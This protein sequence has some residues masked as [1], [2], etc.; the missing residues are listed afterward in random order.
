MFQGD[1]HANITIKEFHDILIIEDTKFIDNSLKSTLEK[2]KYTCQQSFDYSNASFLL[3]NNKFNFIILDLHLPDAYGEE[4]VGKIK[5]LAQDAK[6]IILTTEKDFQTRDSLFKFGI[7]DYI[8]KDKNF[9]KS[10][11]SIDKI[12]KS[13]KNNYLTSILIINDSKLI[14][15]HVQNI[16]SVKNYNIISAF[17][18]KDALE[19]LDKQKIS[20]I[21]LDMELPDMHGLS[22]LQKIKN[23]KKLDDVSVVILSG[24]NNP[25]LL[26][27]SI[28]Q[29]ALDYIK[30]PFN[31]EEFTLKIDIAIS[32][33]KKHIELL[34]NQQILQEYKDA[35]DKSSIVSKTNAQGLIT[36]VNNN[37]CNISG[38]TRDELMGRSHNIVRHGDMPSSI[39]E[40]M[41]ITIKNKKTWAGIIKNRNKDNGSY[42]V[43]TV[44]NPV[45]DYNGNIIEYISIRT[46]VTELENIKQELENNLN[47]SNKN[48][49]EAYKTAQ[50]Y[51]T[52]IDK[53]N[54]LSRA[55]IDGKITYVNQEFCKISA[56]TK[57]EL[58]GQS[59]NIL[60][61][62]DNPKSLYQ[63][64]WQTIS[65]GKI[66]NHKQL[67]NKAKD[68][69]T[70]YLNTTII[71]ILDD[72]KLIEYLAVRHDVTDIVDV[73]I[74][75]ENAQIEIIHKLGEV[76]E[77]RS[78]EIGFHIKRVAE[79]SK[80]LALLAGLGNKNANLL[81]L[82]SPMHDI[83]KIGI[84]DSIL[85]KPGKLDSDEWTIMKTHSEIGYNILKD[86]TRPI[87]KAAAIISY[88]HHEKWDGSGYPNKIF[89]KEIH[90]FARITAIADVF[91]TLGSDRVYK[92]A[93][94]LEKIIELFEAQR[95]KH[96]DPEL[97]DL[98]LNNL[99]QFLEI[100][101]KYIDKN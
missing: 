66:W 21:I 44:I 64:L 10:I 31:I 37:F 96:F 48:F 4:L 90:I 97:V 39:F 60:R 93:W 8:V 28:K 72:D 50:Q 51:Q 9:H 40:D 19:I 89:D 84:P 11:E 61:H 33:H 77:S 63:D 1:K 94:E 85:Q 20:L 68:G 78:K 26:R 76:G 42:Y 74:E 45:L 100:R 2:L 53:S 25:E 83:G 58:I 6:I 99:N 88:R 70:F 46:D 55:D 13:I 56:Y 79:Y 82:A 52:A 30:K 14:C 12:I 65:S 16:L 7:L 67:K 86:S 81:Y 34:S 62:P 27:E 47:I 98:F 49:S 75:M 71:P 29:G 69:A 35:I 43:N 36:Y 92:K 3:K 57:E 54:I 59:H 80:L 24:S 23:N 87:L 41:W 73:H 5:N 22:V 15:K 91:D 18:A 101:D 32:S 38:Y 17:N 95:A